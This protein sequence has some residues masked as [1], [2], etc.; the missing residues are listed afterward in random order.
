LRTLGKNRCWRN[1]SAFALAF[2]ACSIALLCCSVLAFAARAHEFSKAFGEPCIAEPCEGASLK[3]PDGVAVN[4]ASGDVYVVDKGAD[5]VVRF[6]AEGVFQSEFNGSGLLL[7]GEGEP[8]EG[9]AAGSGGEPGEIETGRFAAPTEIAVDNSCA[10]RGLVEPACKAADPSNGDVYVL[11]AGESHRVID[12]YSATGVYLG[13]ITEAGGI[14]FQGEGLEGVAVD[15]EG[16]V[17][18]Y[19]EAPASVDQFSNATP[20]EFIAPEIPLNALGGFAVHGFAVDSKGDFYGAIL[21]HFQPQIA[22]WDHSGTDLIE[23]LDGE[24][25]TDVAVDQRDDGSF[26]TSATSLAAFN[27]EGTLLERLG[28]EGGA[29]HLT[30]AA[31]VGVNASASSLYVSD[32]GS[33]TVVLFG[34]AQPSTPKVES[35]SFEN[36]GSESASLGAQINPRSEESEAPSEYTFQY[37]RCTS[38]T[39][40]ASSGYEAQVPIPDGQIPASFEVQ[41]VSAQL[42]GLTPSTT[43]HFRAIAKNSHGE[44]QAGEERTFTTEGSGGELKLPDNRAWELVSPP[45]KQGA[46]IEP[47]AEVG[48]VEAAASGQ[49]ITYLANSPTEAEPQ[50]AANESQIL[51][52][53][54][55]SAWSSRDI[56]IAHAGPT[57]A[58]AGDGPEYR[59]FDSELSTSAVQPYGEFIPQ[60]SE[61]ASESTAYL[62]DLSE[63]C[64]THCFRPLV[65]GKAGFANVPAG[66]VFG[67]EQLCEPPGGGQNSKTVCGPRFLGA[68]EDMSH[69]VLRAQAALTPGAAPGG[70]YEWSGGSLSLVSVL[71]GGEATMGQLG[72]E[73]S[74]AARRA[75]SSDGTKI[76]WN[77]SGATK[78]GLYSRDTARAET[79]QLDKAEAACE[80]AGECESGGGRFQIASA[81][82]SRVF[83]TDTHRLTEDSGANANPAKSRSDLYECKLAINAG[84]LTCELTDLTPASGGESADVQGS[85]LGASEDGSYIYFVAKGVLSEAANSRGEKATAGQPNLY[86][87][88]GNSTSFIATLAGGDEHDWEEA[89]ASQ[90]TRVSANGEFLELMS[91]GQPTGYDNSN[92]TS[93]SGQPEPVAEVY[94]YDA[95]SKEL[96]CASCEPSGQ[97][98]VGVEYHKIESGSGGLA[99]GRGIWPEA[100]LVAANVPGWTAL[101]EGVTT[102]KSRY[103]P[104]YLNDEGRLFFNSADALVP[105][106]S[107]GTEDVYEYEPPGVGDCAESSATYSARSG[108]CVSLISSGASAQESAFLD[109]S[110]SGDDV[111]FLT[112]A[113]LSALDTD[114]AR[115]VYD[116]HVCTSASPCISYT[117]SETSPCASEA[118]CKAPATPQPSIF[119]APASATFQGPGNPAPV[120]AP[121]SKPKPKTAAQIKAEKL[122]QALKACHAKKNK[123]KRAACEKAARKKYAAK[124]KAKAK[125]A[126]SKGKR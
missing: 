83:F 85:V 108:G 2:A 67:E 26:V 39:T 113:R 126:K 70:L 40:C 45:D 54:S 107:N 84:K 34:P 98:P 75:I 7:N 81:D 8:F 47:I 14:K 64:G 90:P 38:A 61:E 105:Q 104:R 30:S 23:S 49:A 72:L 114:A 36:V 103:Q 86:L 68:S 63:G 10:L 65:S 28:E 88:H 62:H 53:R 15:P 22:K 111:F 46:L 17:W 116:A 35:E 101:G 118:S 59:F 37:G 69:V 18:V 1:T 124:P 42:K 24:G 82:G 71:P 99:G 9:K 21:V 12:K 117:P 106:D 60:L 120:P 20:N 95:A 92:R 80:E 79:V 25:S 58:P 50:G 110:E 89:L 32:A 119:G 76:V 112:S 123:K 93:A 41:G 100:G 48:V 4:E 77:S 52:S 91:E 13:Q 57:G 87:R 6:N 31:G 33:D 74:Q 44:G 29:K 78:P 94:L 66:T 122:K 43:Y 109:A 96:R 97:R 125:K 55:S 121:A 5:R 3:E 102:I 115:D 56:A 11:D 16:K 73:L 19:R 27:P 51:S